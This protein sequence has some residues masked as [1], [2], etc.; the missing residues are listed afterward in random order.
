[1]QKSPCGKRLEAFTLTLYWGTLA[2][3]DGLETFGFEVVAR[4]CGGLR[5]GIRPDL[6][7]IV[8]VSTDCP[9]HELP[10]MRPSDRRPLDEKLRTAAPQNDQN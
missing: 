1:V 9:M 6:H 2:L 4:I 5:G 7:T 3:D 10:A 8:L